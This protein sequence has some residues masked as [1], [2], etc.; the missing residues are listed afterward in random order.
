MIRMSG[1]LRQTSTQI[2]AGKLNHGRFEIRISARRRPKMS[3]RTIPISAIS[4]LTRK[5]STQEPEV[6]AV[7]Q[8]LPVIGVEEV[9]HAAA[10]IA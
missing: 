8:P 3:E 6:V 10:L 9:A 2:P 7:E 4:R 5:P 1:R